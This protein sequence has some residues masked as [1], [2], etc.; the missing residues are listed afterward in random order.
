MEDIEIF[1][2]KKKRKKQQYG[3]KRYKNL[4]KN[5]KQKLVEHRKIYYNKRKTPY[6]DYKKFFSFRK[7]GFFLGLW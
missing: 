5:E 4:P 6:N 2:K 1:P 7:F 3:P